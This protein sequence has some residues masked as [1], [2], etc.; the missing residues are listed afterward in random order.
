VTVS[1]IMAR[2]RKQEKHQ[3]RQQR[4]NKRHPERL[5]GTR[6]HDHNYDTWIVWQVR[7]LMLRVP[8]SA[9]ADCLEMN[10]SARG[11]ANAVLSRS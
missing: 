7:S 1:G 9:R 2:H 6:L 5:P 11:L 10:V 4:E 3:Q 8:L